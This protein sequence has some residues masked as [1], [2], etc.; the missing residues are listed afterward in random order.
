MNFLKT[1]SPRILDG[2]Y[3]IR[4]VLSENTDVIF[5]EAIHQNIGNTVLIQE[6]KKTKNE[7]KKIL[8][9]AR[10]LGD[11]AELKSLFQVNDYFEEDGKSYIVLE[12]PVGQTLR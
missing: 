3:Q 10:E 4:K 6:W 8:E 11:F 5:Y 12:Y 9:R 2:R 1:I 7:Q